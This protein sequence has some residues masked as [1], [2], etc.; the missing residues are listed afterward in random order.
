LPTLGAEAA[1]RIETLVDGRDAAKSFASPALIS[2][3]TTQRNA[4]IAVY[5]ADDASLAVYETFGPRGPRT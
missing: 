2:G 3:C 4:R 5:D 1:T